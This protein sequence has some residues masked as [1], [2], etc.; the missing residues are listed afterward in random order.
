MAEAAPVLCRS[1]FPVAVCKLKANAFL[2]SCFTGAGVTVLNG[3]KACQLSLGDWVAVP[4]AGG[5]LG[6]LAVQYA[7]A[8]GM[9]VVGIDTGAEKKQMVEG[10]GGVFIDFRLE[11]VSIPK[12]DGAEHRLGHCCCCEACHRWTWSA[13]CFDLRSL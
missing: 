11:K 12:V 8:S 4:G 5:G 3:L 9:K 2:S 7:I 10:Y 13:W 1:Q 6:H